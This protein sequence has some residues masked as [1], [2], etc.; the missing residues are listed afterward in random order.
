[1]KFSL[2]NALPLFALPFP[3]STVLHGSDG[4]SVVG[5][6]MDREKV[7]GVNPTYYTGPKRDDQLF[8]IRF[9][10]VAPDPPTK[11]AFLTTYLS[12]S[13]TC[14]FRNKLA[15]F[16]LSG[17]VGDQA[18]L[19]NA[20]L[21]LRAWRPHDLEP[22]PDP[23]EAEAKLSEFKPITVRRNWEYGGPLKE[24]D[25][26]ILADFLLYGPFIH[27]GNYTCEAVARLP[28]GRVFS[29]EGAYWIEGG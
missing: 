15:F 4:Q 23:W 17:W 8:D 27:T 9:F 7:P 12:H 1:M 24:G 29:F 13:I 11:H 5:E 20:T 10:Q 16:Y 3:S 2:L 28:D 19:E 21:L 18:G 22:D 6:H 25:N 14:L 26:E